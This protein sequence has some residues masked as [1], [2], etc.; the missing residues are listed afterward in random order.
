MDYHPE[1]WLR[2]DI[3][4]LL[5]EIRQLIANYI[6][7]LPENIVLIQNA[8]DGVN[9]IL[10]SLLQTPN[11]KVLVFDI[12]Y[13]MVL[14]TLAYL[15]DTF[16]IE[17]TTLILTKETLNSDEKILLKIEEAII[18]KGP[19]KLA[20]IDHISSI[21]SLIFPVKKLTELLRK[22]NIIVL[23]DGAHAVGHIPLDLSDINPDFYLSN[24][25]KWG[26]TP[27]SAAFLYVSKHF[28]EK[29]HP[30]IIGN[31]YKTNFF[32][33][34]NNTGTRDYS[35]I[36]TIKDALEWRKHYGDQKI[37]D[38]NHKL[39]WNAG[40][41]VAKLWNTEVFIENEERIGAMVCVRIPC[42]DNELIEK[43][44]NKVLYEYNTYIPTV[45]FN[46]GKFYARFSAQV[47]NEVGDFIKASELFLKALKEIM[48]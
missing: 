35:A 4:P 21:P 8:S 24:F 47:F 39:A 26:F 7:A 17:V 40:L 3:F 25:H 41:E 12:S 30:N 38:F 42:E 28:Q 20:C 19:F 46:D 34:F 10:R 16:Q 5:I 45:K 1:K 11:E 14:N 48:I 31:K 37:M 6:N 44:V 29:I 27:K 9:M 36:L 13:Q 22:H 43:I 32:E 23:I 18:K 15:K 33:E 2:F